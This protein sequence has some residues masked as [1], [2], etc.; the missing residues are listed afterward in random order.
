MSDPMSENTTIKT[1]KPRVRRW[2]YAVIAMVLLAVVGTIAFL[3]ANGTLTRLLA[4]DKR[5]SSGQLW[6]C[7]MHPQVIQDHPG[8]C[9]ICHM[10][11]TPLKAGMSASGAV[12]I[13]PVV[14]QNMGI[15]TAA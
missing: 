4:K 10:E 6:T 2:R 15:R 14:V 7:G 13:D 8:D 12:T 1:I 9:P 11:L 3:A 5:A